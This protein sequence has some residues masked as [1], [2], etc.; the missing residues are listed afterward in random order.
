M[1]TVEHQDR[2]T[3][4]NWQLD[5]VTELVSGHGEIVAEYFDVG[6]SRRRGWRHRPQSTALLAA[7]GDPLR[8]FNHHRTGERWT[9]RT[10]AAILANPRYTGRQ[11]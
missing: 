6:C 1:S 7:L 10:V 4:R 11:V 5:C 8:E 3:S 9:L 2:A